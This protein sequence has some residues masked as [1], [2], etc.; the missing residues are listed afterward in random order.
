MSQSDIQEIELTIEHAKEIV[1]RGE[2]ARRLASNSDFKKLVL[3]GY[4]VNEAAR[5]ALLHSDP[6]INEEIREKVLR[7]LN[8]P[9]AFKRYLSTIIQMGDQAI[10]EL[11]ELQEALDEARAEDDAVLV[12]GNEGDL[13]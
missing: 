2:S 11:P 8:G 7:D 5:L 1:E 4:F 6:S 10:R 12:T 3:D 13:G 9:G